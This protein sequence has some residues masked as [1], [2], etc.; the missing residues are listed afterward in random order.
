MGC[1]SSNDD[2]DDS[3]SRCKALSFL[4]T[5]VECS[6]RHTSMETAYVVLERVVIP[7]QFVV[8]SFHALDSFYQRVYA[9]L[10]FD[11]M[12]GFAISFKP[13]SMSGNSTY[14][15]ATWRAS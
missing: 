8:F 15:S 11:C 13:Q 12:T 7:L 14:V 10:L 1:G 2:D 9:R 4:A 5:C 6:T 3:G